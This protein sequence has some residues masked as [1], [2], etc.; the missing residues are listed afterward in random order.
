MTP[1]QYRDLQ[2]YDKQLRQA[3]YHNYVTNIPRPALQRIQDIYAEIT[4]DNTK[5]NL[6]CGACQ[7]KLLA[8]VGKLYFKYM[9]EKKRSEKE[10][11]EKE[12]K[13]TPTLLD[14]IKDR[15]AKAREA[16]KNKSKDKTKEQ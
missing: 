15:M 1:E 10:Q 16:K 9:E 6:G 12:E 13:K 5:I 3:T 14:N 2:N 8:K 7:L 11:Q 4:G